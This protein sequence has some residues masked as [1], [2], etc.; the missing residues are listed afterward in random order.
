MESEWILVR[1]ARSGVYSIGSGLGPVASSCDRG[2]ELL[3]SS[4]SELV[5]GGECGGWGED[6]YRFMN[7]CDKKGWELFWF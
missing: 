5:M 6:I 7:L 1:C 2:Y 3:G 4:A